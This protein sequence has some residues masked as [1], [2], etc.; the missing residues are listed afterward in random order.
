[1][2]KIFYYYR[3]KKNLGPI[4]L[5]LSHKNDIDYFVNTQLLIEKSYWNFNKG[6]PKT[7]DDK[8]KKAKVDLTNLE[9]SILESFDADYN[10]GI[11]IT[12]NWLQFKVDLFFKRVSLNSL[13]DILLDNIQRIID[14]ASIRRNSKGGIGLSKSRINS[15]NNLKQLL[16]SFQKDRKKVIKI[17]DVNLQF[18]QEFKTYMKEKGYS[19]SYLEKKLSD[20]KT[21]CL[22]AQIN[23]IETS[24]QLPKVTGLK[25]KN[26]FI[27]YLNEDDLIKIKSKEFKSAAHTN[28]KR[29]LLL[30]AMIGQRG[31]DL[32]SL[33]DR[34]IIYQH[35]IK[36]I[37]LIQEK[38][39]K[40]VVIPFSPE[41]EDLLQDGFPHRISIQK[42]NSY[43]KDI[44]K[45][46][47]INE[48]TRGSLYDKKLKR[49]VIDT[50]EKW[51]LISSHD[52]RRSMASNNY[53]KMP[54][55]LIMS[56]TGHKTEAMLLRYIGKTSDDYAQQIADYY[57]KKA[58]TDNKSSDDL[59]RELKIAK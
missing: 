52:L 1:M 19:N 46:A 32:L 26:D 50:Y 21:V 33:T 51:Q 7:T 45:I 13:S 39:N 53:G 30:G 35:G 43:L 28:A 15:Y 9:R 38:G 29:W 57:I 58:L 10:D 31:N 34:N 25:V 18:A 2:A 20:I 5:R 6:I 24:I 14:G 36:L 3:S 42:F 40:R 27:I 55:P 22:D 41:M 37:E 12:K 49:K 44:C 59:T 54:T 56:I 11:P 48:Q 4:T 8:A 47:E 17:K 16:I 23:G